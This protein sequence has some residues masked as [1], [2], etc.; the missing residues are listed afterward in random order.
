MAVCGGYAAA[1]VGTL[2]LKA[3]ASTIEFNGLGNRF[4]HWLREIF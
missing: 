1:K 4:V 2:L 3:M